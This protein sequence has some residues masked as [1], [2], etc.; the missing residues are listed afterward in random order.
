MKN[1]MYETRD[2]LLLHRCEYCNAEL[3]AR[4]EDSLSEIV[5]NHEAVVQ[6]IKGY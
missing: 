6:C 5:I 1:F 3:E 4:D 2:G